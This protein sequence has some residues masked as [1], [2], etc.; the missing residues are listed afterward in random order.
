MPNIGNY[1]LDLQKLNLLE[2]EEDCEEEGGE[3]ARAAERDASVHIRPRPWVAGG[4]EVSLQ[5]A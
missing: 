1:Y 2:K 5:D 3:E 4:S